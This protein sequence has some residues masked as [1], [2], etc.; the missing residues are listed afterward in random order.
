MFARLSGLSRLRGGHG[1]DMEE[2]EG[3][4]VN[5]LCMIVWPDSA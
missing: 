1:V 3:G 4:I 2:H 5:S